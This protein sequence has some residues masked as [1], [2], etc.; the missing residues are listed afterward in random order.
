MSTKIAEHKE[1]LM[2]FTYVVGYQMNAWRKQTAEKD[3]LKRNLEV[4][5]YVHDWSK[6]CMPLYFAGDIEDPDLGSRLAGEFKPD[7]TS[8]SYV[9]RFFELRRH[10]QYP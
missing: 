2:E 5:T 4:R 3:E 8:V 6:L 7:S 1:A 9:A 10:P